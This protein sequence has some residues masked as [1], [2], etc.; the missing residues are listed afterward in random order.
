M[1]QSKTQIFLIFGFQP[2][3]PNT[4]TNH[5]HTQPLNLNTTKHLIHTTLVQNKCHSSST[6]KQ[7]HS[8]KK[9]LIQNK[10]IPF[11]SHLITVCKKS[12][13]HSLHSNSTYSCLKN[14]IQENFSNY[15]DVESRLV[16]VSL[17]IHPKS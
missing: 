8:T 5:S 6:T 9:H 3:H 4:T 16:V 13:F 14:S 1:P 12:C 7:S 2:Q 17:A 10:T 11:H 15:M